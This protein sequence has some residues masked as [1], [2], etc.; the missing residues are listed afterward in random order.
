MSPWVNPTNVIKVAHA[1]LQLDMTHFQEKYHLDLQFFV[2]QLQQSLEQFKNP[3]RDE[4][5][6]K[7]W[8]SIEHIEYTLKHLLAHANTFIHLL[9]QKTQ[10][11]LALQ[12]STQR[13]L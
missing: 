5:G 8:N 2:A 13:A 9:T 11:Q 12:F 6:I 3:P 1:L 10:Q 4:Y 7:K